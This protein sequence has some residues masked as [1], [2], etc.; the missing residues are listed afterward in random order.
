MPTTSDII[1]KEKIVSEVKNQAFNHFLQELA[2]IKRMVK[3]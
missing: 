2:K 3:D 1:A